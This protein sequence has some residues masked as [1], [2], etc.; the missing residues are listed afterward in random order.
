M[1]FPGCKIANFEDLQEH[2]FMTFNARSYVVTTVKKYGTGFYTYLISPRIWV[3]FDPSQPKASAHLRAFLAGN[4]KYFDILCLQDIQRGLLAGF[5]SLPD[6]VERVIGKDIST[7]QTAVW[8][9]IAHTI[10][11]VS[12][13]TSPE[14]YKE[15]IYM[16]L[17]S[18]FSDFEL[19]RYVFSPNISYVAMVPEF[20]AYKSDFPL[21]SYTNESKLLI[22]GCI[23]VE[24][25]LYGPPMKMDM[26]VASFPG[27][28]FVIYFESVNT[29]A[30][31]VMLGLL[32]HFVDKLKD[33]DLE[34][35]DRFLR[36]FEEKLL[37]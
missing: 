37:D 34:K 11:S 20:T 33:F 31:G 4:S 3:R 29:K 10:Q 30:L 6:P 1:F 25:D 2:P 26:I 35:E 32:H 27:Q 8:Y 5:F 14:L 18:Y 9:A 36:L 24:V 16:G 15:A 22:K 28:M 19:R 7:S 12:S 21:M 13:D 17:S 23:P